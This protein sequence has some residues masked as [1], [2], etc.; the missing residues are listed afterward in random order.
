MNVG[1]HENKL[2]TVAIYDAL[3]TFTR[4]TSSSERF[5]FAIFRSLGIAHRGTTIE[6][7]IHIALTIISQL[8]P[9]IRTVYR[10]GDPKKTECIA[11]YLRKGSTE[12]T[13][14]EYLNTNQPRSPHM[15]QFCLI[16]SKSAAYPTKAAL[17]WKTRNS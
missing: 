1:M 16:H 17:A 8:P 11:K 3:G 9:N 10:R 12:L 15:I 6:I 7:I 5:S 2:M 14:L 4:S 13:I